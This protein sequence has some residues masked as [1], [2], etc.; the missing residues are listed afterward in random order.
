MKLIYILFALCWSLKGFSQVPVKKQQLIDSAYQIASNHKLPVD[1]RLSAYRYCCWKT[2]YLDFNQGLKISGE[3][4]DLAKTTAQHDKIA[5]AHHFLGHSYL[6]LGQIDRA[7][8]ILKE[9]LDLALANQMYEGVATL[10]GDLGNLKNSQGDS[11]LA[12]E[13]HFKCLDYANKHQLNVEYARAKINIGEIYEAQGQYKLSIATFQEALHFCTTHKFGGFK[14]SI[15][16]NLGNINL[17]IKE[18]STA[19]KHYLTAIS[20]AKRLNNNN[21][22]IRSLNKLGELNLE[23]N[24]LDRALQNYK[25]ALRVALTTE[26]SLLE[27]KV[28]TNLAEVYLQQNHLKEAKANITLAITQLEN[29]KIKE[30]LDKAYIIAAKTDHKLNRHNESYRYYQKAYRTAKDNHHLQ[31]LKLASEGLALAYE[32]RGDLTKA[33]TYYKAYNNYNNQIRNEEG[34]RDIIR[35]EMQDIYQK[36]SLADSINKANE[37]TLLQYQYDKKEERNRLRNYTALSSIIILILLVICVTYFYHQKKKIAAVLSR[38]N[39]VIENALNDKEILLKEVHHRVKNNMQV[40]SSVLYLKSKNTE[41]NIAKKAL[42][43]SKTRI[44]AMQLAH[45]KMYLKGNYKQID[46]KDYF[47]DIVKLLLEPIKTDDDTFTVHGTQLWLDVEQAQTLGLIL[48]ELIANSIKY[49][50][51]KTHQ[52]QVNISIEKLEQDIAFR[53]TD[54]GCGLPEGTT[55]ESS[56]SFGLKLIYALSTRQLLGKLDIDNSDGFDLKITFHA[57]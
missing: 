23:L 36:K 2:V 11:D 46:V 27:A 34:I 37:I 25:E 55:I 42:I 8:R 57:R 13:Y 26:A 19:Q 33:L 16:E 29:L 54:N 31:P 5:Q 1:D 32:S 30:D 24:D 39:R 43:D 40:V 53:Y 15:Y 38:K 12:L 7:K 17:S 48:H 21:R 9:G 35:L 44:D 18:Y 52:K 45:Q 51:S 3:Y 56:Q 4:L 10:Y 49:A 47:N 14:S 20:Y 28:R 22:L 6:M 50:W 41:N